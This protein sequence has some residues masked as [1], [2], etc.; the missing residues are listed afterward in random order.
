M[1][2]FEEVERLQAGIRGWLLRSVRSGRHELRDGGG[3]GV[4]P[5]LCAAAFGP[6]LAG[7]GAGRHGHDSA[8]AGWA[9]SS[10]IGADTLARLLEEAEGRT[11]S[12]HLPGDDHGPGTQP[13]LSRHLEREIFRSVGDGPGRARRARR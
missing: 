12:A 5:L 7:A 11:R 6:A 10:S 13:D 9:C 1:G 8:S 4:L 3:S 2:D